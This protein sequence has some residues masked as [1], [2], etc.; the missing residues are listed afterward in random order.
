MLES[1][2][3]QRCLFTCSRSCYVFCDGNHSSNCPSYPILVS[4]S[5]KISINTIVNDPPIPNYVSGINKERIEN[6]RIINEDNNK[7]EVR[8]VDDFDSLDINFY[9]TNKT[10]MF[11]PPGKTPKIAD[12]YNTSL[13]QKGWN[14]TRDKDIALCRTFI[15][16]SKKAIEVIR[17][18]L[19][20]FWRDVH[21]SFGELMA[22]GAKPG[23]ISIKILPQ[24]LIM[25]WFKQFISLL[26]QFWNSCYHSIK[27]ENCSGVPKNEYK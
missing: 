1:E 24:K 17:K 10:N 5:T 14:Y 2:Q 22:K 23:N 3:G 16:L 19:K 18:K 12:I 9:D 15:N 25:N 21:K 13:R 7:G 11:S 4:H 27:E 26:L 8:D 6:T 20:I